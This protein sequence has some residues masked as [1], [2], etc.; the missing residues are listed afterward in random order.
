MILPRYTRVGLLVISDLFDRLIPAE[1]GVGLSRSTTCAKGGWKV[2]MSRRRYRIVL[3]LL[4]L[5]LLAASAI[6]GLLNYLQSAQA[7]PASAPDQGSL[8]PA[9]RALAASDRAGRAFGAVG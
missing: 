9:E 2:R 3:I 4:I 5:I 7:L 1:L 6:F 8:R